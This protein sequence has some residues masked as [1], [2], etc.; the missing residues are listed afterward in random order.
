MGIR[1]A[2]ACSAPAPTMKL[3]CPATIMSRASCIAV[4]QCTESDTVLQSAP[5]HPDR[6][7]RVFLHDVKDS[8]V[9]YAT[10]LIRYAASQIDF[11]FRSDIGSHGSNYVRS[12]NT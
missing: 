1:R 5:S 6:G 11:E 10:V 4:L 3:A 7:V 8:R 12:S 9:R 2:T